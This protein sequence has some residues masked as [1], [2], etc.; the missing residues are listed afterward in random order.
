M[1]VN[2]QQDS[3]NFVS[4]NFIIDI[5]VQTSKTTYSAQ[6]QTNKQRQQC[7]KACINRT[8]SIDHVLKL[9]ELEQEILLADGEGKMFIMSLGIINLYFG[10]W[11]DGCHG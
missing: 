8:L 4:T 7:N 2:V 10:L 6:N 3:L 5:F 1:F 9:F 11:C